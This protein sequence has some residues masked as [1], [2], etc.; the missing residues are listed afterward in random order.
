LP[1]SLLALA[2][3][4]LGPAVPATILLVLI[5]MQLPMA[6][7]MVRRVGWSMVWFV[8]LGSIRAIWRAAGLV[9]GV[10]DRLFRRGAIAPGPIST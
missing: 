10:L 4:P 2:W 5:L 8:L 3:P 6:H 7:A 1:P 9:Q